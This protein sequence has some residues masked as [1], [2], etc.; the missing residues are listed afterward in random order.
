MSDNFDWNNL[1]RIQDNH[2]KLS[3][4]KSYLRN[5]FTKINEKSL[6]SFYK[7]LKKIK[8]LKKKKYLKCFIIINPLLIDNL[9]EEIFKSIIAYLISQS[10]KQF[11]KFLCNDV[12]FDE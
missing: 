12:I 6:N 5:N 10:R 4:I 7:A 8:N 11:H 1:D 3:I 2:I 9:K